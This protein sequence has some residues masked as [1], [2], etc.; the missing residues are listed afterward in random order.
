MYSAKFNSLHYCELTDLTITYNLCIN[1]LS[2]IGYVYII[3]FLHI[4]TCVYVHILKYIQTYITYICLYI[5]IYIYISIYIYVYIYL[6]VCF[7]WVL[8][9]YMYAFIF[10][11]IHIQHKHTKKP[12]NQCLHQL[13]LTWLILYLKILSYT[14]IYM[15]YTYII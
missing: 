6:F 3:R 5:Y 11:H 13:S 7:L 8:L 1:Q 2:L 15:P 14:Y 10:I 9:C 12:Y 4:Y